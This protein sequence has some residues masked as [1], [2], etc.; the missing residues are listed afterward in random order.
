MLQRKP[1]KKEMTVLYILSFI[2]PVVTMLLIF[3]EQGFYPFGNKS[4]FIMDMRDQYL[5]FFAS[6]RYLVFGDDSLFFS[7]S[8]SMGGNYLGL[9][10]Y[11]IA[12]PM[13]FITI[14]FSLENLP[15]AIS[16]LTILKIGLAGLSFAVFGAYIWQSYIIF[17]E[18]LAGKS[19]CKV[20]STLDS[21]NWKVLL[22]LPFAISYAL[23]SYNMVYS[24]CLMWLDGVILLPV[25]LLGVEKILDGCKG[26]HYMFALATLF[27]CN[28]YTGYMVGIFTAIYMAYRVLCC[29]QRQNIREYVLKTL[30]FVVCTILAF[31]ISAPII[32]PVVK[33]LAQ[34]K[35]AV[36]PYVP[37]IQT[38][39]E[40]MKLFGKLRN[41]VYDSIQ[42]TG[43]PA[44][45]CGYV[46]IIFALLFFI[47]PQI[48]VKEKIGAVIIL[49]FL[50]CSFYFTRLDMA[51]HGFQYPNWFPYRYAFV[52]SFFLLYMA[53]FGICS[54]QK[55]SKYIKHK[56]MIITVLLSIIVI[57]DLQKNGSAM[58]KG[59]EQEF[60]Y[61][62]VNDYESFLNKTKP[63]VE[64]AK[65]DKGF[66]R[67]NQG[68]EFS[69]N[70]A[71]LLGYHGMTH[72]SSTF[73]ASVNLLTLKL[74]IAQQHI[75]NSGYGSNQ[76]LDSLFAVK[77]I[78][79]DGMV[80]S[81]YKLIGLGELGEAALYENTNVLPIAYAASCRN[82]NP[83]LGSADPFVNQNV[84]LNAIM[85]T[86]EEYFTEYEYSMEDLGQNW[87]YSFIADSDNPIYLYMKS[88]G[89][90]LAD[91]YVNEKWVGNYF[92]TESS[93]NLY[94]GS[95]QQGEQV[96]VN[97]VP[98]EPIVVD[99]T[100]IGQLHMDLLERTLHCL[101]ENGMNI[102]KHAE[103]M[104]VGTIHVDAQQKIITS[105]PFDAGWTV[106]ID[107][108]KVKAVKF[109]DTFLMLDVPKG[110]HDIAFYYISPGFGIGIWMFAISVLLAVIY[111]APL[112]KLQ[113]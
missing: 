49:I 16:F 81:D 14:F 9:F 75:W 99:Y 112:Q 68:Y 109:A 23:M 77:Y 46:V 32:L 44:I 24:M 4:L 43:L 96:V 10:A 56:F 59:L 17:P 98:V 55:V 37:D 12:S 95:F 111:F 51:W 110:D 100:I 64:Q 41:G 61:C 50:V 6:L 71:M 93:C 87:N 36:K 69:K 72:Y 48:K 33:D 22:V 79:D 90:G 18:L 60:G 11:Y 80:P 63:L 107:G 54:F 74:G 82:A 62:M 113:L 19:K 35:L 76:L 88:N 21:S 30:R 40:F 86:Q 1:Q 84:F 91:V 52:G 102:I 26:L 34:G 53:L 66:Y 28:Y 42:N 97:V 58:F 78:I 13:S 70:D 5:E 73:N 92:Q 2:I 106:K 3:K 31:G 67:I 15:F 57:F 83:D 89:Y 27:I 39:F 108:K 103:G 7:W 101:R 38:N 25:V 94:L 105:I 85:G 45:Y 29:V 104:L 8:R 20:I 47:L 65:E